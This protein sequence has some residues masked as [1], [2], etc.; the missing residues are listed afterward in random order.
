MSPTF[1]H[2]V[3]LVAQMVQKAF[4]ECVM[5]LKTLVWAVAAFV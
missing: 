1:Q 3:P 5:Y 2:T 4:D